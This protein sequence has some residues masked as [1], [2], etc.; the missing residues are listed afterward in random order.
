MSRYKTTPIITIFTLHDKSIKMPYGK[1]QRNY[2]QIR[3]SSK[4][5]IKIHLQV[6]LLV[7]FELYCFIP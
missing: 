1:R 5:C 2:L 7:I 6:T 4:I 3:R